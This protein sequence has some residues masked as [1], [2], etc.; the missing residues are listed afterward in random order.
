MNKVPFLNLSAAT[1]ELEC[2]IHSAIDRVLKSGCYILGPEVESFEK[3]WASYCD[4]DYCIGVGN[5][6]DSL[7][8][9]LRALDVGAGDEV[10]VPAHT[11]IATWLAVVAVGATPVPVDANY[12][13]LNIDVSAITAVITT[14]TKAIIPVHLY[15]Q[16]ADLD[17]I[18]KIAK[19]HN[20][21]VIEDA[22]QAHGAFWSNKRIG[23]H[24]DL[25]CWSFYPGKNL[26]ALGD[27]G[28]ITTSNTALAKKLMMLR[29]YGAKE[30]YRNE[31]IGLNSRLDPIQAAVLSVKL[32]YLDEW[33]ARRQKVALRY[34]E[35]FTELDL[36]IT[37]TDPRSLPVWH[38]FTIRH[39]SR[40]AL[41]TALS[42]R[43][44]ETLIHYPIA[45]HHQNATEA[46]N[47]L[48]S[49]PIGPHL[50]DKDVGL[51]IDAVHASLHDL[52]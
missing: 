17:E 49:L 15:G 24:G 30:K 37:A 48:L 20:L 39:H 32:A 52:T 44:I 36:I 35:A 47:T 51:V 45:P 43:G 38:L 3:D 25:V 31:V 10:I 29:N 4:S 41:Q 22:A 18:I 40:G 11:F 13:T 1:S 2:D 5:G 23:Q 26:G 34:C 7:V 8:L 33:T 50:T 6:L 9:G 46:T 16:S 21:Y 12:D 42:S 14:K 19:K 27:A 28:A